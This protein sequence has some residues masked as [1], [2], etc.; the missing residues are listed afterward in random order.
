MTNQMR[1][2]AAVKFSLSHKHEGSMV[3]PMKYIFIYFMVVL[4][5][6]HFHIR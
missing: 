5:H 6:H 3:Y 4:T 2:P 1:M